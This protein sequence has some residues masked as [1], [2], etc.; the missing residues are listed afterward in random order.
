MR[1][2]ASKTIVF[3]VIIKVFEVPDLASGNHW[4]LK[5]NPLF[6]VLL[7]HFNCFS[8]VF[9]GFSRGISPT[10]K[11]F[12]FTTFLKVFEVPELASGNHWFL[13]QNPLYFGTFGQ[14]SIDFSFVF[15]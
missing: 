2:L 9:K 6:F 4:F 12:V 7:D 11:T 10:V 8:F 13:K 14:T 1:F 3:L 15:K 5:Q